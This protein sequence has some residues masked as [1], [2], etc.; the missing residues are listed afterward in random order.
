MVPF[1]DQVVV[2]RRPLVVVVVVAIV[3]AVVD[4]LLFT[5]SVVA[6]VLSSSGSAEQA[7]IDRHS[8]TDNIIRANRL[9]AGTSL[10][11]PTPTIRQDNG[12]SQ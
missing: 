4:V 2:V 1:P 9:M 7:T 11:F 6:F 3:V 10:S 5:V 12:K 8:S